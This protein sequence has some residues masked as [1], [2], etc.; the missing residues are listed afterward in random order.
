MNRKKDLDVFGI[1]LGVIIGILIGYFISTKISAEDEVV[2]SEIQ[3][4]V[5]G[6][7]YL[8]QFAKFDNPTGALNYINNLKKSDIYAEAVF[9]GG[10]YYI[11]GAISSTEAELEMKKAIFEAKGFS[12]LIKKEYLI[13]KANRVLD[14]TLKYNFWLEG[15]NNLIKS[16]K[17]ENIEI[18]DSYYNNPVDLEFFSSITLLQTIQNEEIKDKIKLQAYRMIIENLL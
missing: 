18:S 8:L 4:E 16:L 12:T 17:G 15:I 9:D 13:D 11:Y 14:D 2:M 5:E 3:E 10:Y 6:Y 7:V 1:L